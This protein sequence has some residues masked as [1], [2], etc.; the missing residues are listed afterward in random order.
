MANFIPTFLLALLATTSIIIHGTDATEFFVI[1]AAGRSKGG[2]LFSSQIGESYTKM[3]MATASNF[4]FKMFN[5]GNVTD[6]KNVHNIT[7]VI[8]DVAGFYQTDCEFHI[9]AKYL[10]NLT[11]REVKVEFTGLVYHYM[12]YVLG[13]DGSGKAPAGLRSGLGDYV[14]AK[15]HYGPR[16][17]WAGKID[18][19]ARWDQ[20]YDVTARFLN[21][22]VGLRKGFVWELNKMMK[23]GYSDGFFKSLTGKDVDQLWREYKAKYG[24]IN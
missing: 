21:Y 6:R 23:D 8:D 11:S 4:I 15:A 13:W 7:L 17:Y 16:K 20:G 14:R 9:G 2:K 22:C 10:A 24:R 19:G 18:L 1:N 12:T 3:K 5:Q